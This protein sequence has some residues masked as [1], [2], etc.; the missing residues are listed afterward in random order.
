MD[1]INHLLKMPLTEH[2]LRARH[3]AAKRYRSNYCMETFANRFCTD[4]LYYCCFIDEE[5]RKLSSMSKAKCPDTDA[6]F[7]FCEYNSAPT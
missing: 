1:K 7:L 3:H 5:K 6:S 4:K 2:L